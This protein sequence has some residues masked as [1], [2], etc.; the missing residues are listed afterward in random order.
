MNY[1]ILTID[2]LY[3]K[4]ENQQQAENYLLQEADK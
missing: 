2:T 4:C 3:S 1:D